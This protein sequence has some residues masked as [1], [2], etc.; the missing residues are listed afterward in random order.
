MRISDLSSYVCS[1]DLF[2]L[3]IIDLFRLFNKVEVFPDVHRFGFVSH[4][5]LLFE[6]NRTLKTWPR[7]MVPPGWRCG[8]LWAAP[9]L[10]DYR[11]EARRVGKECVRTC[12]TWVSS[13]I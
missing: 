7:Y 5:T 1:S 11:S 9:P 13:V 3:A 2:H 10:R 4:D 6:I 12:S 8:R